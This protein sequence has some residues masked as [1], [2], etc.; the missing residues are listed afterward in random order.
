MLKIVAADSAAAILTSEF[1]PSSIVSTAAVKVEPPYRQAS[2]VLSQPAFTESSEG[3]ELILTELELCK[4]LLK[5]VGGN[6][7]HLDMS[8]GSIQVE[9]LSTIQLSQMR[10]S[11]KARGQILKILPKLRKIATD[12]KRIFDV[13]VLAI[14]KE[15]VPVRIA[16]L[17]A[18][19]NSILYS[20]ERL[21]KQNREVLWLG[22]PVKC[23]PVFR[24]NTVALQSLL[25]AEHDIQGFALDVENVLDRVKVVEM[26]NPSARGF[27]VLKITGR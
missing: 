21:L 23:L 17:T 22:L 11:K 26:P 13:D 4:K 24:E 25:P 27:R 5:K 7:V 10:V 14:G 18:G 1:E 9:A 6:S 15:S 20:A 19:A 2:F 3:H 12:L 8:L 16:E